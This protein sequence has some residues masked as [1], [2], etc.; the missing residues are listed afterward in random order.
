M[1]NSLVMLLPAA[2]R[3]AGDDLSAAFGHAD[4]GV[5]TF[6][7]PLSA[8]GQDPA[9]HYG[10]HAW[11]TDQFIAELDAAQAGTLTP[12]SPGVTA[13]DLQSLVSIIVR[14]VKPVDYDPS[15]HFAEAVAAMGLQR[16]GTSL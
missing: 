3:Q 15:A 11:A 2:Q 1:L 14:S 7:V 6:T 8:S 10:C 4:A 9:T 5:S 12:L 13:V 16:I